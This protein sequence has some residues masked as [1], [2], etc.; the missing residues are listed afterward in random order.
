MASRHLVFRVILICTFRHSIWTITF[1]NAAGSIHPLVNCRTPWNQWHSQR[2]HSLSDICQ[3]QNKGPKCIKT[4]LHVCSDIMLPQT[5][6][7]TARALQLH[8]RHVYRKLNR[9]QKTHPK[10]ALGTLQNTTA[11]TQYP[12]QTEPTVSDN[13]SAPRVLSLP[14]EGELSENDRWHRKTTV[15]SSW[16]NS[17]CSTHFQI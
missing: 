9:N 3:D 12:I 14:E 11:A 16:D 1:R 6:I 8:S 4:G 13:C 5:E 17:K 10:K 15:T 2:C 7:N